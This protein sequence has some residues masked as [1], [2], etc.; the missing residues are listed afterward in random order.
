MI[1]LA[2]TLCI[3]FDQIQADAKS[4]RRFI[5]MIPKMPE[6]VKLLKMYPTKLKTTNTETEGCTQICSDAMVDNDQSA[7]ELVQEYW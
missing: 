2:I 5:L 3:L 7:V 4:K 1:F 6:V